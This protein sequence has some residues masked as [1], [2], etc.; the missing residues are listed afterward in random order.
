M[1]DLQI[2]MLGLGYA[3]FKYSTKIITKREL[4]S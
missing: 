1:K 4:I 2:N 3:Y